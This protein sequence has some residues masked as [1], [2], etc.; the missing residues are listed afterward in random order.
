VGGE[1]IVVVDDEAPLRR[2]VSRVLGDLGYRV[3]VAGNGPEAL[4]LIEDLESAPDLL[5]TDVILPAGLQG[6]EL[7]QK[8]T[9]AVPNLPVLYM[10]GHPRDAIMHA[11]RLDHG[12]FF[13]SKPFTPQELAAK[14]QEVLGSPQKE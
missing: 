10:S 4:E 11:G 8:L 3:F 5:V 1:T 6:N 2:L 7:A 9:A 13:L 14:V 12:V